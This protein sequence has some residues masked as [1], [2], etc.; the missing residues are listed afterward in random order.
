MKKKYRIKNSGRF[1]L[2]VSCMLLICVFVGGAALGIFDVSSKDAISYIEVEVS[3]GDTIWNIARIYGPKDVDI[4]ESVYR[5]CKINNVSADTL[6]AG[7]I[8]SVP[9]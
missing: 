3:H 5:I 9:K 2:F 4:R 7:Q 1:I 6:Q 8:L